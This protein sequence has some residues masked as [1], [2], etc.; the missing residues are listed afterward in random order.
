MGF[1]GLEHDRAANLPVAQCPQRFVRTFQWIRPSYAG[2]I[3][4]QRKRWPYGAAIWIDVRHLRLCS[5]AGC[6]VR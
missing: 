1:N 2:G 5:I 4:A 3:A 6:P